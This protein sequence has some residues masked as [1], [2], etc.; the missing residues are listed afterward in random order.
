MTLLTPLQKSRGDTPDNWGAY[1]SQSR[2]LTR[3]KELGMCRFHST[4]HELFHCHSH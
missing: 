4:N 1:V 2:N 3:I